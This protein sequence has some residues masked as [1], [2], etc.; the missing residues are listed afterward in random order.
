MNYL[1]RIPDA[2]FEVMKTIWNNNPPVTTGML[3]EQLGNSKGWQRPALI[4][5]LIRLTE[6]GFLR[7]EKH[8]K[9][10]LYY[11]LVEKEDYLKF[12]TEHFVKQYHNNSFSSLI[13]AMCDS[14]SVTEN[15]LEELLQFAKEKKESMGKNGLGKKSE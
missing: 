3:M 10:R 12:E 11:P 8:G 9:E 7:S 14:Q 15:E 13:A 2:E 1:K 4:T 5:L 6:R